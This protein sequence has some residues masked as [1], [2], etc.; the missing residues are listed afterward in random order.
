MSSFVLLTNS[1]WISIAWNNIHFFLAY[2]SCWG[3][4]EVEAITQ[5]SHADGRNSGGQANYFRLLNPRLVICSSPSTHSNSYHHTQN[6]G[7]RICILC[8]IGRI[9]K[10]LGIWCESAAEW[11]IGSC[12][13]AWHNVLDNLSRSWKRR[14]A[15]NQ[16]YSSQSRSSDL[17]NELR[18]VSF[19]YWYVINYPKILYLQTTTT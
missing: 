17:V 2:L 13:W 14:W 1:F 18:V 9:T 4:G 15:G 11:R 10:L 6:K 16:S 7:T 8:F 19:I 12:N 5:S 3:Q